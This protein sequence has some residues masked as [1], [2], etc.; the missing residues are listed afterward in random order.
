MD[1]AAKVL[2]FFSMVQHLALDPE[3]YCQNSETL[4]NRFRSLVNLESSKRALNSKSNHKI[5]TSVTFAIFGSD[6]NAVQNTSN[7]NTFKSL[8]L[9]KLQP[10]EILEGWRTRMGTINC[11]P[12]D[13]SIDLFMGKLARQQKP[14]IEGNDFVENAST[15]VG[16]SKELLLKKHSLSTF[17]NALEGLRP[18]K[19]ANLSV[20]HRQA[21]QRNA[22]F[23][24]GNK[25]L[26]YCSECAAKDLSILGYSYWRCSHQIPGVLWCSEHDNFLSIHNK[27]GGLKSP[28]QLS[29]S[30]TSSDL[31]ALSQ[32][33]I[34]ILKKYAQMAY[35]IFSF[36]SSID[37][38]AASAALGKQAKLK[39]FR[40]S[41]PGLKITP[42]TMLQN[43]LPK[44]WLE[45]TFPRVNWISD[46]YI[47]TI[48]GACSPSASRYT[49]STLCLLSAL[50]YESSE[51]AI[52]DII[53]PREIIEERG[54][55]FW[56]SK[57]MYHE[58]ISHRGVVSHVA[59]KLSLPHSSVGLGLLNQGL[60]GLGKS[61]STTY[62]ALDFLN[63]K[64][65][66]EVCTTYQ[67]SVEDIEN[68]I[69]AGCFKFKS[70]LNEICND[71]SSSSPQIR[72]SEKKRVSG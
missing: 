29:D 63:G 19:L 35:E 7:E 72:Y 61:T 37:S 33:Q 60:P 6:A 59:E 57:K 65:L 31:L 54:F 41:K 55:E 70:A 17:F 66:H 34:T 25:S 38:G 26:K 42:S 18:S 32:E 46:K 49:T 10:D 68:L 56:G 3:T 15:L 20:K 16:I 64:S 45:E 51:D 53:K 69:R 9:C 1:E 11:L 14:N 21:Y 50:F 52:S 43:V 40:I 4:D 2:E 47:W 5:Q 28:H 22:P 58:Y 30:N 24:I 48:D 44:W 39:N 27:S 12:N 13:K 67:T 36:G 23:R 71:A 62:A 8:K